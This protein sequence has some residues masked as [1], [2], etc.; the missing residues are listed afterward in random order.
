VNIPVTSVTLPEA[1]ITL[2]VGETYQLDPNITP[3]DATNT[4]ARYSS[5]SSS[6]ASV[7]PDGLIT[8]NRAGTTTITVTVDGVSVRCTVVVTRG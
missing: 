7:S 6:I 4:E 3:T 5:R 2:S 8:A 1:R